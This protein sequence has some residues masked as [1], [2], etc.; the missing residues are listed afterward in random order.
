MTTLRESEFL[1]GVN[2]FTDKKH[3]KEMPK[4]NF[5]ALSEKRKNQLLYKTRIKISKVMLS[6]TK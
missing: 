2:N 1:G 6:P 5:E 3:P 4:R